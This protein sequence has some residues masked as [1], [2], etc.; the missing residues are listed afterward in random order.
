M[1]ERG[2]YH[3]GFTGCRTGAPGRNWEK[4]LASLLRRIRWRLGDICLIDLVFHHGDCIGS[5]AKA[6]KVADSTGCRI[7]IHPPENPKSRAYCSTATASVR[8]PKTY[9]QRNHDIVDSSKILIAVPK[10]PNREVLRSGTWA[11]IRYARKKGVPV[12]ML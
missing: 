1:M 7:V 11:T 8:A 5:D 12:Y 9:L 10:D 2:G 4:M 6:H 3:V